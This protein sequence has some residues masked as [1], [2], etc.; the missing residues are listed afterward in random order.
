MLLYLPAICCI[1]LLNI[2]WAASH[3]SP[4]YPYGPGPSRW[5]KRAVTAPRSQPWHKRQTI[6]GGNNGTNSTGGCPG[7]TASDRGSWCDFSIDTDW[8]L[9]V[10]DTGRTVEYYFE[11]VNTT[12]SPDGVPKI[13]LTVNGTMPGPVIEGK[14]K[15]ILSTRPNWL[16]LL[17]NWGDEVVVHFKNNFENNG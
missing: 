13:V 10:P 5:A 6:T 11:M 16:I 14:R 3:V 4:R 8:Y 7:N 17:A 1:S 15:V 2:A 9:E 12:L